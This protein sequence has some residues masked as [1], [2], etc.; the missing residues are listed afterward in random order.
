[1]SSLR[2]PAMTTSLWESVNGSVVEGLLFAF[3][4][5][6]KSSTTLKLATGTL[7]L[8]TLDTN[9]KRQPS[10]VADPSFLP[11][12]RYAEVTH[13]NLLFMSDGNI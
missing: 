11:I 7:N 12:N 3:Y 8:I 13:Q 4:K 6:K 1:M 10:K 9:W 2:S 5:F